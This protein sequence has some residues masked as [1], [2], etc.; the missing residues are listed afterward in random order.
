[1]LTLLLVDWT[2]GFCFV[3]LIFLGFLISWCRGD[4]FAFD[5]CYLAFLEW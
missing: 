2:I 4:V 5:P 1:M 3:F